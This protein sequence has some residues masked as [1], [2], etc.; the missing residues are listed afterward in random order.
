V[1]R[2]TFPRLFETQA[3]NRRDRDGLH[4]NGSGRG[5][6]E[7][8]P[9]VTARKIRRRG[10]DR[11]GPHLELL[12]KCVNYQQS[13]FT[14]ERYHGQVEPQAGHTSK[15]KSN[16]HH[17]AAPQ[18]Q[19]AMARGLCPNVIGIRSSDDGEYLTDP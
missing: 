6:V 16:S 17:A 8:A 3:V 12:G 18:E 9:C 15:C 14:G 11:G 4:G 5:D 1:M 7:S 13:P 19:R 2:P 10:G